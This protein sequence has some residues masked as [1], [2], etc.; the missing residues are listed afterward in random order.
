MVG[1]RG[2]SEKRGWPGFPCPKDGSGGGC[3]VETQPQPLGVM[4]WVSVADAE[5]RA[6]A[7]ERQKKDNHNLSELGA[8]RRSLSHPS[9]LRPP[10]LSV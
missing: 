8:A 10:S 5:S 3:G 4:L 2:D 6:L 7:K 9:T 1:A